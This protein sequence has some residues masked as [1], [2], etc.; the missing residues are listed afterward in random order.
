MKIVIALIIAAFFIWEMR[1]VIWILIVVFIVASL[2]AAFWPKS[3][4]ING[5]EN[6]TDKTCD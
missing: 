3:K 6:E 5:D 2:V 4:P 1:E